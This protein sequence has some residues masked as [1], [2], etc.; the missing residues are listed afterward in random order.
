MP[1][2]GC[3]AVSY[4]SEAGGDRTALLARVLGYLTEHRW[5]K[6]VDTGWSDWDLGVYCHHG[7]I[8]QVCTV[9]EE[10][11]SG[12]RALHPVQYLALAYGLMPALEGRLKEPIHDLVLR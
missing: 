10:H 9:Q 3:R 8:L 12:K 6:A 4:W 11:G 2:W 5:G 7:F 1:L